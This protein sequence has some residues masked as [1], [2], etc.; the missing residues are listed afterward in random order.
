MEG[1]RVF[2]GFRV[3]GLGLKRVPLR[4]PIRDLSVGFWVLGFR[5]YMGIQKP[6][7][8]RVLPSN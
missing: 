1:V 4:V 7:V 8:L 6:T 2:L 5:I 3:G